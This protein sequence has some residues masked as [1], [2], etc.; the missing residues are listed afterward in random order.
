MEIFILLTDI[1]KLNYFLNVT[2]IF[3]FIKF[4]FSMEGYEGQILLIPIQVSE[5]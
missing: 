5:N 3:S 4:L 2:L 1:W